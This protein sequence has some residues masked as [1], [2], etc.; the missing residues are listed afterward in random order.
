MRKVTAKRKG[1]G[2]RRNGAKRVTEEI[3][4]KEAKREVRKIAGLDGRKARNGREIPGTRT[5]G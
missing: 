4:K 3:K 1:N 5:I 2:E